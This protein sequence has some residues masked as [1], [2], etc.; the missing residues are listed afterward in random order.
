MLPQEP[1]DGSGGSSRRNHAVEM[2]RLHGQE[3]RT[4]TIQG[5]SI[6]ASWREGLHWGLKD[7]LTAY[8]RMFKMDIVTGRTV[9]IDRPR[10]PFER[11]LRGT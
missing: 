6:R 2:G 3:R 9:T 8:K 5:R 11:P 4:A 10:A 7:Y 1:R